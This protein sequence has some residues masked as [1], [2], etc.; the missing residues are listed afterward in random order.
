MP[1]SPTLLT[2]PRCRSAVVAVA[3]VLVVLA[4]A[5]WRSPATGA[6]PSPATGP[7]AA[8]LAAQVEPDGSVVNPNPPGGPSVLWSVNVALALTAAGGQQAALGSAL[9][10]I[11]ANVEDYVVDAG[12]DNAGR[13]AYLILL[14]EANDLDPRAFGAPATDLVARLQALY[15]EVEA[16]LYDTPDVYSSV[17]YQSLAVLAL[18]AAGE[19]VPA[20]AVDWLVDQQCLAGEGPTGVEG[21]WQG[22]RA[23]AGGGLE[24]CI[25]DEVN[26]VSPDTSNT[27]YAVQ[28]L[29]AAGGLGGL[30]ADPNTFFAS[31][32][33]ATGATAGGFGFGMVGP[34]SVDPNSTAVV[35]Q[36][37]VAQGQD[38]AG[39]AVG[40]GDPMSSL[41]SWIVASGP[42]A[43]ALSSPF[44]VPDADIFATYQG[45][46][47]LAEQPFPFAA[48]AP[49]PPTT[50]TTTTSPSTTDDGSDG[51]DGGAAPAVVATPAFT[52]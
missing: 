45:V 10:Y 14:A 27:S 44:L 21:G 6:A 29:V 1:G 19:T 46:W 18:T 42:D 9:G 35:I 52:G 33:G 22:Y 8:W 17:T 50:T 26:F 3:I 7:A 40:G 11:E 5:V 13:L 38:L 23:P 39:W 48:P 36:A 47:G 15:G 41:E 43:G 34:L 32:Q 31:L 4:A 30:G 49:V 2:P 24:D 12:S 25:V 28:A 51:S 20:D 37:L 16:G